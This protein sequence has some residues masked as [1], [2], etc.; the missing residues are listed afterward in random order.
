M[1]HHI[2]ANGQWDKKQGGKCDLE[3]KGPYLDHGRI[4][5]EQT[6]QMGRKEH[7]DNSEQTEKN[8]AGHHGKP[9][10]FLHPIIFFSP[11][12]KGAHRLETLS[13]TESDGE[14]EKADPVD[15]RHG[16]DGGVSAVH[17]G[18]AI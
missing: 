13:Q 17:A 11:K 7:P 12:I 10:T 3:R 9:K 1:E 18:V 15:D 8:L 6:D 16:G 4:V 14:D 2:A 5:P